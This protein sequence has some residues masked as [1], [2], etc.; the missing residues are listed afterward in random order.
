MGRRRNRSKHRTGQGPSGNHATW[1]QGTLRSYRVGALP[2]INHFLE[3]MRVEEILQEHLPAEDARTKIAT[4]RGLMLLEAI[5]VQ[6][7]SVEY[8]LPVLDAERH[9]VADLSGGSATNA[10]IDLT[11]TTL[12]G[13]K[14][15]IRRM[16]NFCSRGAG[17]AQAPGLL[18][19]DSGL[20]ADARLSRLGRA[21]PRV[22]PPVEGRALGRHGG[23]H[24]G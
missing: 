11:I 20:P 16:Y 3:C 19:L 9:R 7:D 5:G 14:I 23:S 4:A 17:G 6:T 8:R 24:H 2:I 15:G 1:D 18:R 21:A 10:D 22:E 12:D 13:F